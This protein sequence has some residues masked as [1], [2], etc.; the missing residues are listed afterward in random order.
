[1]IDIKSRRNK[2]LHPSLIRALGRYRILPS[3]TFPAA[4]VKILTN[5]QNLDILVLLDSV[6]GDWVG[7][8]PDNFGT[9]SQAVKVPASTCNDYSNNRVDWDSLNGVPVLHKASTSNVRHLGGGQE[10]M[11]SV[12][13]CTR[14]KGV[15][16]REFE[17]KVGFKLE[18]QTTA[19]KRGRAN[20]VC[21]I[22]SIL[23]CKGH[24]TID[25]IFSEKLS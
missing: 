11:M 3:A 13:V 17:Q 8:R 10:M 7:P 19:T 22:L 25:E 14:K 16:R 24:K 21:R 2:H 20:P 12:C 4:T 18:S 15:S 23:R 9:T 1:M 6:T 5:S